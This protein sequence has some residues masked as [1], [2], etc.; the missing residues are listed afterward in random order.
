MRITS[1]GYFVKRTPLGFAVS[2]A[3]DLSGIDLSSM[4][5]HYYDVMTGYKDALL[6]DG[7]RQNN[8]LWRCIKSNYEIWHGI[9]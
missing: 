7:H 9:C 5:K 3:M 2:T 4:L 1:A 6:L 8:S